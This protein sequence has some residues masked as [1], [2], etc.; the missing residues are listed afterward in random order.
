MLDTSHNN[1]SHPTNP[2][3]A[4]YYLLVSIILGI[5][6]YFLGQGLFQFWL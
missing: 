3:K 1:F 5:G 2:Q 4:A 6:I